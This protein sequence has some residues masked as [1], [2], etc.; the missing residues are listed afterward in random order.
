MPGAGFYPA[1]YA[2]AGDD[3]PDD[4]EPLGPVRKV[5]ANIIDPSSGQYVIDADGQLHSVHPVDQIVVHTL[6]TTVGTVA[7]VTSFGQNILQGV[8][9]LDSKAP[10]RIRNIITTALQSL[11]DAGDITIESVEVVVD[12]EVGGSLTVFTYT[13]HRTR[14][15]ETLRL[16]TP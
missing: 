1:G 13:N 3:P 12:D 16:G 11:I 5:A 2:P 14:R 10:A 6:S 9:V 7:S 15:T 8:P 4:G